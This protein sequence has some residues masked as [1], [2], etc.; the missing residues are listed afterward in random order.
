[1]KRYFF[2]N[3]EFVTF[4]FGDFNATGDCISLHSVRQIIPKGKKL[5]LIISKIEHLHIRQGLSL[6]PV[7]F[8]DDL[9]SR[10]DK[11]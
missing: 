3:L 5:A 4:F 10:L 6:W 1:M 7:I 9:E 11:C 8:L 2:D